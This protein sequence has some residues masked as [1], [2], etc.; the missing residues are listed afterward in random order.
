MVLENY[1]VRVGDNFKKEIKKIKEK[2]INLGMDKKK[3]SIRVLSNL[4]VKHKL[5]SIIKEDMIQ[6]VLNDTE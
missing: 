2:R 3:K 1:K 4:L 5:W 6:E